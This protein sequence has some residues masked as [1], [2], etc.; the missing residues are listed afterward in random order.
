MCQCRLIGTSSRACQLTIFQSLEIVGSASCC[1]LLLL[2][3]SGV[4]IGVT[5]CRYVC[6]VLSPCSLVLFWLPIDLV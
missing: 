1:V 6:V 2:S 3:I 5:V 4:L